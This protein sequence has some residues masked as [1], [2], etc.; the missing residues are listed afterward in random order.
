MANVKKMNENRFAK[1]VKELNSVGESIRMK[2]NEKQSV[3]NSFDKEKGR[4]KFGKI[5]KATL[6]SSATKSN[7]EIKKLN[8]DIRN[9]ISK[10]G[11]IADQA[12]KAA[13]NTKPKPLRVKAVSKKRK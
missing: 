9:A 2:E 12:K 3:V 5:S 10:A 4:L 1:I 6:K 13:R 8:K 7:K 11:K